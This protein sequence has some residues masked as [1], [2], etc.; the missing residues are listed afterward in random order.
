MAHE[1]WDTV[2]VARKDDMWYQTL[3]HVVAPFHVF[4]EPKQ[5]KLSPIFV[6]QPPGS[7]D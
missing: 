7:G 2:R 4:Y 3:S 5:E 6:F 1:E